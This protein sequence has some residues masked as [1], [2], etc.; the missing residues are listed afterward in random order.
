MTMSWMY[1]AT[2]SLTK[3]SSNRS[4]ASG[5]ESSVFEVFALSSMEEEAEDLV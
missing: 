2:T 4:F 3:L 1:L 5:K